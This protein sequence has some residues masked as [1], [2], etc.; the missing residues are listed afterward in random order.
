MSKFNI[1]NRTRLQEDKCAIEILNRDNEI[2][3]QRPFQ[4]YLS[5]VD[6]SRD[7]YFDSFDQPGIFQTGNFSGYP[8]SIDNSSS[9]RK[10]KYGNII[11]NT[12]KKRENKESQRFNPPFK[13]PQT[14][15]LN[16]D[17]M[18]RLYSGELTKDK[19]SIR[20]KTIDRFI[21]LIPELE[22]QIQNPKNLI[23][24]Y[25]VRGGMDTKTVI[26]NIDYLKSCGLKR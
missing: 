8:S 16:T 19:K 11:T 2:I 22:D 10:G 7:K 26:R 13:G 4:S 20:G 9:L 12:G 25:W 5:N 24:K 6:P 21:P 1:N 14:M 3:S 23:P 15:E 17:V 18:S